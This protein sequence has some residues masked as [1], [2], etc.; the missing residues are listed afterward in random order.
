MTKLTESDLLHTRLAE[1]ENEV[2]SLSF[3]VPGEPVPQL[4][5][6]VVRNRHGGQIHAFTPGK[7]TAHTD[8]VR[9]YA[10]RSL[11]ADFTRFTGPLDLKVDFFRRRP[12]SLSKKKLWPLSRPD[13]SN[14]LKL[15]EDA[16]NGLL[17]DDDSQIVSC[18]L[19]KVYA[20]AGQEPHTEVH[21]I[22]LGK[23]LEL[24]PWD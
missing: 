15:V 10:T 11:P 7:C 20:D 13:L 16:L 22:Q 14:Y 24:P 2:A 5:A 17:W 8:K 3:V 23:E 19:R 12:K 1:V 6:Q 9:L 18:V 21:V 4:R